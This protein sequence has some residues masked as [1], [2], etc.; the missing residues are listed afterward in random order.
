MGT[1]E[2]EIVKSDFLVIG[3]GISGLL[4]AIKA[5]KH[6]T[7]NLITKRSLSDAATYYAQGG[8]AAVTSPYDSFEDHIRDTLKAGD[9]LCHRDV[10]EHMV[11]AG[12][13]R[14][15]ELIELGVKFT[16]EN[17]KYDLGLEGGHSKRRVLHAKDFTGKEIE[18]ALIKGVK[19]CENINIF[20]NHMSINLY[21]SNNKVRGAY[22]LDT[23]TGTIKRFIARVVVLATGGAGKVFLYTSN[24]DISTGDGIAMAYRIGATIMNMEFI[25]F[26]P[27][28]LYHP[29][30]KSFLISEALRG[31]GAILVDAK[32]ERF[33]PKYHPDA[34]LAPRDV[35]ARAIDHE[36]KRTGA[37]HVYLD[38]SFKDADYI[39][40]RFPMIYETC[41]K[42]GIDIT[43]EPIPV[44]PAA[45]YLCGGVKT[46]IYGRT[47]V[48]NLF[49]IGETAATGFHG[50]N[51]MASNSLLEGA[52]LAH[53]AA[54]AAA[55]IVE[56]HE[57]L[58]E[59][60]P[61]DPGNAVDSD[62]LVIVTHNW[63]EI[64][65]TMWNY[66]GIVRSNK[67]LLRARNRITLLMDEIN[68]YYW[69]FKITPDLIELRNIAQVAYLIVKSA[70]M[71]R[72]SRGTHYNI[73][74][75]N[76]SHEKVD[77]IIKKGY[78]PVPE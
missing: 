16:K 74:Y 4:F 13:E 15:K 21:A 65:R 48:E 14:I 27:T 56:K 33:M 68:Q 64:R 29:K 32:G 73:D 57:P 6:G 34:E 51:R 75:P 72:E 20:E 2:E 28:I 30:V 71:R 60:P 38:I 45:H 58:V 53:N 36:L 67:R 8:I 44:V 63:D 1:L 37:D 35:V 62:E 17:G 23:T 24:P 11:R 78:L 9:G 42:V 39:K 43:Q 76:K 47:D 59:I 5:A 55:K 49:A 26:H 19:Q 77:T 25:Q 12:P 61:W 41:L 70:M 66:V 7:V 31:E 46:D 10:V 22:I 40:K 18:L 69:D 52:V 54:I 3:S 50:A